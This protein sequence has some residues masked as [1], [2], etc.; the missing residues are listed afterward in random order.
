[1][2]LIQIGLSTEILNHNNQLLKD[3]KFIMVIHKKLNE[4]VKE[5]KYVDLAEKI[6]KMRGTIDNLNL[7]LIK[8]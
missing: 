7:F 8:K 2:R 5:P 3:T 4:M 6:K 1:M